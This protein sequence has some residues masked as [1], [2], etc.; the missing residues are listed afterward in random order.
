MREEGSRLQESKGGKKEEE[1]YFVGRL[2]AVPFT[3]VLYI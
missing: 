3:S 2:Y 1:Q